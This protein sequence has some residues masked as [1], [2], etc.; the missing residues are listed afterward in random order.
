MKYALSA[1]GESSPLDWRLPENIPAAGRPASLWPW[2]IEDGSLTARLRRHCGDRFCV[3]VLASSSGTL[4][5]DE[6]A[7]TGQDH[8]FVR[9]VELCCG[10]TPWVHARTVAINGGASET[11]L[12]N[13]G[14]ESL[15][16][17]AFGHAPT[18]RDALRVACADGG[19]WSR[20]SILHIGDERIY[21]YERFLNGG[22]PWN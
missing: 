4:T 5:H 8:G 18:R 14:G 7:W 22:A 1:T 9:E 6:A 20:R 10:A 11:R 21:I 3:R 12:R 15:G 19:L 13:L 17:G 16:D 2:L